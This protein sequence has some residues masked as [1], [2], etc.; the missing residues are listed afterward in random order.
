VADIAVKMSATPAHAGGSIDRGAP[1]YGEDTEYVY[2]ELLGMDS[3]AIG[4]LRDDGVI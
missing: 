2:G 4:D 1:C 3:R